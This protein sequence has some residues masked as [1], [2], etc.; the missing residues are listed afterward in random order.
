MSKK[1]VGIITIVKVNNYGAE[2]Q[3]FATQRAM[4]NMGYD[5]EIIDYLFYKHKNH[6]REYCSLPFWKY[7]LSKHLREIGAAIKSWFISLLYGDKA[8][9]REMAFERFH[10]NTKFSKIQY[11]RYSELY[12]NPPVY[13]AYCVGSDQVWNPFSYTN[14]N[15]YFLT[16]A[17]QDARKFS[18]AS[19]FGLS[20]IPQAAKNIYSDRLKSINHISVRE[21]RGVEIVSEISG[22]K[23]E[24]VCDP[25]LLLSKDEWLEVAEPIEGLPD[26]YVL[27][28]QLYSLPFLLDVAKSVA[29]NLGIKMVRLC[30]NVDVNN[31]N[32][33]IIDLTSIGPSQY[34]TLFDKATFVVTNS[35]HG[36]AFCVNFGKDFY[37]V[38]LRNRKTNSRQ[39]SLLSICGLIDRMIYEDGDIPSPANYRIN[40]T[41]PHDLI[42]DFR[43]KS[44]QFIKNAIDGE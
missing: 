3:A 38:A 8:K 16:F 32:P 20:E 4:Q 17:S 9:S 36:T 2:L 34:L 7:P 21:L 23:A 5:S 14:L 10:E 19:S 15:P 6:K 35:F 43:D 18:Y 1:K 37:S 28:Y 39:I 30:K 11:R 42:N 33:D 13:D 25:T 44:K 41:I 24:L 29:K 40:Y 27:I 22:Q 26:K 12:N 31:T